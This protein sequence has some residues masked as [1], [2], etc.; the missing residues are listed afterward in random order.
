MALRM[1]VKCHS[2]EPVLYTWVNVTSLTTMS[3]TRKRVN[4]EEFRF[5]RIEIVHVRQTS[6]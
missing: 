3:C 1:M 2:Q 5:G 6:T 4:I